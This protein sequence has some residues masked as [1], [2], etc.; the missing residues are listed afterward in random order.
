MQFKGDPGGE[1]TQKKINF[2]NIFLSIKKF[3]P[4]NQSNIKNNYQY[5]F[6]INFIRKISEFEYTIMIQCL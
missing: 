5:E 6:S 1:E 3:I 2:N 4:E